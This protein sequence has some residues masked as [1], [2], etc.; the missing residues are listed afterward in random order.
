MSENAPMSSPPGISQKNEAEFIG[1]LMARQS[2]ALKAL[3]ELNSK[4]EAT[5]GRW[6]E[7]YK[8]S[9]ALDG[10]LG[11]SGDFVF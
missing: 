10:V 1:Q 2:Q 3:D 6:H 5:L 7:V 8:P 11:E 4:I 9:D